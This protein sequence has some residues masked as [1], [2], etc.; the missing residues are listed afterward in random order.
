MK[1]IPSTSPR[2][3]ILR[4]EHIKNYVYPNSSPSPLYDI[5]EK[6]EEELSLIFS[7]LASYPFL[8]LTHVW[9]E[10][11]FFWILDP[12]SNEWYKE[13]KA[14]ISFPIFTF[15]SFDYKRFSKDF[16][17][18]EVLRCSRCL[19]CFPVNN[20][21][22]SCT[23]GRPFNYHLN[24]IRTQWGGGEEIPPLPMEDDNQCIK[25][26]PNH[27]EV[28]FGDGGQ[29]GGNIYPLQSRRTTMDNSKFHKILME[30]ADRHGKWQN[31]ADGKE[32]IVLDILDPDLDP[33][34]N[35]DDSFEDDEFNKKNCHL[36]KEDFD[37]EVS[38]F[39]ARNS[40][41][42]QFFQQDLYIFEDKSID[43]LEIQGYK[44]PFVDFRKY[45]QWIP[46]DILLTLEDDGI[47]YNAIPA[48]DAIFMGKCW[49]TLPEDDKE[50]LFSSLEIFTKEMMPLFSSLFKDSPALF[51][52]INSE[53]RTC[54]SVEA[55][56]RLRQ[57]KTS[58]TMELQIIIKAQRYRV[59]PCSTYKGKV[60]TEGFSE[61]IVAAGVHYLR[62]DLNSPMK[63]GDFCFLPSNVPC[64]SYYPFLDYDDGKKN[65]NEKKDLLNSFCKKVSPIMDGSSLVW[66]NKELP[67]YMND[68]INPSIDKT[69]YR[70]FINFFVID[71]VVPISHVDRMRSCNPERFIKESK[72]IQAIN[73][74]V[75][76]K[77]VDIFYGNA[78]ELCYNAFT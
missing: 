21:Y 27:P 32:S 15:S 17:E 5:K 30:F 46:L 78:G 47:T 18:N 60:H 75:K 52:S 41:R 56:E 70:D 33:Y 34:L 68:L 43:D 66:A 48:D 19:D 13:Y 14:G 31:S 50:F 38:F 40:L 65:F 67:H 4:F 71:R 58:K 6:N 9:K 24:T 54:S 42:N 73:S 22:C 49:K 26:Y 2:P 64:L 16:F 74:K 72:R 7:S 1:N 59:P 29:F 69:G 63:G 23:I 53:E 8:M 10:G 57:L 28:E 36:I 77:F 12:S 61:N 39:Y 55:K 44:N 11:P 76:S 51:I 25:A 20:V 62:T 3:L 35:F 45:F 37:R